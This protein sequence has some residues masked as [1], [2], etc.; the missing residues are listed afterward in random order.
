MQ[1]DARWKVET[2]PNVTIAVGM[3]EM[4]FLVFFEISRGPNHLSG[5]LF[6]VEM[7]MQKK[8]TGLLWDILIMLSYIVELSNLL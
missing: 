8:E 3:A 7:K 6:L 4:T 2:A 1:L 5:A